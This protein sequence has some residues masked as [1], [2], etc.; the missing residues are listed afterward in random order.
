MVDKINWQKAGKVS[1]PGRY[2]FRFGWL[3][4]SA[5]DVAVWRYYPDAQFTLV[6][7]PASTDEATDA[8]DEYHLGLFEL[9]TSP[10]P[11]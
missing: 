3:T 1:E 5:D 4:I 7:I 6:R 11:G 2:M 10:R 8:P 9:P